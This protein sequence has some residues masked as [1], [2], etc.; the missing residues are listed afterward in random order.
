[1]SEAVGQAFAR[2]RFAVMRALVVDP[3]R[4]FLWR[5]V[6]E[7]ESRGMLDSDPHR[8]GTPVAYGDVVMEH[9]LERLRPSVESAAGRRLFPTYSYLRLYQAGNALEPHLDRPACEISLSVHLGQEQPVSWPLWVRGPRGPEAVALEPGDAVLYRG[10]EVEHW[11]EPY[12]GR[13]SAQVF[14]HYVDQDGPF[15][16]WK[17]D[18]RESLSMAVRLPI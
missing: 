18:K 9:L 7:R 16:E 11:R 10:T 17:F 14:L 13:R 8:P 3:L 15:A 5:Y 2:D 12:Q 4:R 1:M 6:L